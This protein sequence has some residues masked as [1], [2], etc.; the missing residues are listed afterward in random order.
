MAPAHQPQGKGGTGG[1]ASKASRSRP[2]TISL[3]LFCRYTADQVAHLQVDWLVPWRLKRATVHTLC[4]LQARRGEMLLLQALL[5]LRIP[6]AP[7]LL[8]RSGRHIAFHL[9]A[10]LFSLARATATPPPVISVAGFG[11]AEAGFFAQP[12]Q[13]TSP[14]CPCA[15]ELGDWRL[16]PQLI[17]PALT[18]ATASA[19]SFSLFNLLRILSFSTIHSLAILSSTYLQPSIF[20]NVRLPGFSYIDR[21][22]RAVTPTAWPTTLPTRPPPIPF[23]PSPPPVFQPQKKPPSSN[24]PSNRVAHFSSASLE[25]KSCHLILLTIDTASLILQD[26]LEPLPF[27]CHKRPL[28]VDD[29]RL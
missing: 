17:V 8:S 2:I 20:S 13:P 28:T 15:L 11:A 4:S 12:T 25:A 9:L 19:T 21:A 6:G 18:D 1:Q 24:Q 5:P 7:R 16:R 10:C 26:L 22:L 23:G 3:F 27:R 29:K 14:N